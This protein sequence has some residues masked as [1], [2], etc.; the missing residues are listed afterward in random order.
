MATSVG[1]FIFE[2]AFGQPNTKPLE[3]AKNKGKEAAKEV[4][5]AWS[6]AREQIG[7]AFTAV[8]GA[9]LGVAG[10]LF[11]LAESSSAGADQIA[12]AARATGI[13]SKEFQRLSF[14]AG[15]SGIGVE[16]LT[17]GLRE[18]TKQL[19][20]A[21]AG[22]SPFEQG[23]K[24]IGLE[25]DQLVGST[26]D[27]LGLIADSLANVSSAS[28]R[29]AIAMQILG[30]E[31][32]PKMASLLAA[33]SEGI[34][35][36]GDEAER[37]GLVLDDVT[38][39]AAEAFQDQLGDAKLQIAALTREIGLALMPVVSEAVSA[40]TEWFQANRELLK[41]KFGEYVKQIVPVLRDLGKFLYDAVSAARSLADSVGGVENAVKLMAGAWATFK[42]AQIISGIVDVTKALN[43]LRK[44]ALAANAARLA[45]IGVPVA[46]GA[47]IAAAAAAGGTAAQS[48]VDAQDS[49]RAAAE[50]NDL[51]SAGFGSKDEFANAASGIAADIQAGRDP[52]MELFFGLGA[53]QVDP[54][55]AAALGSFV[56]GL[57]KPAKKKAGGG[58]GGGA[59]GV[60]TRAADSQF[61][62]EFRTL[63]ARFGIGDVGVKS[64]LE[65]SARSLS[66]GATGSVART[67]GL[68]RLGGL[69]GRDLVKG[70]GSN[71]DPLM[72]ELFGDDVPDVELSAIARGAEP[73][74]LISN[75]NNNFE[76]VNEFEINGAGDP[77]A[78]GNK[79]AEA[80]RD[81][82]EGAIK[83]S[84]K[85]TK[86]VFSR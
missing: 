58:G 4:G 5:E 55:A 27:K 70:S 83:Q 80:I 73:Q 32:G 14:I 81:A 63:A 51:R 75:I 6:K 2:L 23:L 35:A 13:A 37:L 85:T 10:G 64:A 47:G 84:T 38:L 62:E 3:E 7:Q 72:S 16:E 12:K 31:A 44:A 67:A 50:R 46:I 26:E 59:G 8:S 39:A 48:Y 25:A 30:P 60:D 40:F 52:E 18:F 22:T 76:F 36:M 45:A 53:E 21:G 78:V 79:V 11:A 54:E 17:A 19:D 77:G 74:V 61:G 71:G 34:R 42:T 15:R 56:S 69:A 86:V 33:G 20:E 1:E 41:Q 68:S 57:S 28:E 43:E 82:F 66:E 29:T 24:R 65:A 49:A 9:A